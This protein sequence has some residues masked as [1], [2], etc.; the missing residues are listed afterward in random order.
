[1]ETTSKTIPDVLIY[2][3]VDGEPIYY[4]GYKRYL[5][6]EAQL[7]ELM[8]SSYLQSKIVTR[9]VLKLGAILDPE[10]Y[11]I[12]VSEIGLQF[13]D[14]SWRAADLAIFRKEALKEA[15]LNNKYLRVPPEVVLEVDT[16]ADLESIPY[17]YSYFHKKTEQLLEHGARKVIW[18]YTETKKVMIAEPDTAWRIVNWDSDVEVLDGL[19]INVAGFVQ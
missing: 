15:P 8:G 13:T 5:S 16:K 4:R 3:M 14:N 11:E 17:S 10:E 12:L 1:M 7:D 6:G 2:E 19:T 9:L 18:I